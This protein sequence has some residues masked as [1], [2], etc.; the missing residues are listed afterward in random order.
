MTKRLSAA[1]R[2]ELLKR[3]RGRVHHAKGHRDKGGFDALWNKLIDLYR[4]KHFSSSLLSN[5]EDRIAV[6]ICFATINVIA[7]SIA[8]NYPKLLVWSRKPEEENQAQI[9]ETVLNYWWRHFKIQ[10]EAA[11]AVKDYLV[12]GHGWLK[13]G[14]RYVEEQRKID[15]QELAEADDLDQGTS[16]VLIPA[17][18][19]EPT[20]NDP[21]STSTSGEPEYEVT[22]DRPFV[23]RVS[24]FDI[25][26]DPEAK[27]L[28]SAKWICQKIVKPLEEVRQ[29]KRY[30]GRGRA[31]LT[32][33]SQAN[34]DWLMEGTDFPEDDIRRVT[35]YEFYDMQ[36]GTMC[37]FSHAGD[38][39]LL[40]PIPQ[41]YVFGHPFV[42]LR[43]YEV[44]DEFYPMGDVEALEP[45]QME[46]D[47]TR[48]Q[49]MNHRKRFNRKW[50]Y[51]PTAF[52]QTGMSALNKD[53]DNTLVPVMDTA[54]RPLNEVIVPIPQ[55]PVEPQLY[56]Y[57]DSTLQL[58]DRVSG[59]SEYQQGTTPDVRR[60]A[61]EASMIQDAANSRAADKMARVELFVAEVA[62][63]VVQLAQQYMTEDQVVRVIGKNG[64]PLWIPYSREDIQGE[65]DFEVEAGSTQPKNDQFRRSQA[66]QLLQAL[67]PW[68]QAGLVNAQELLRYALQY[69][70]Q[71]KN[72]DEFMASAVPQPQ[73]GQDQ[74]KSPRQSLIETMNYRDAPPDIQRQIEQA[75]GFQPSQVGGS[76]P[77]EGH[78]A[79]VVP[80][81]AGQHAQA[82]AAAGQIMAQ[83]A[84][85]QHQAQQANAG[86][87]HEAVMA[88]A[89]QQHD[90]HGRVADA[91]V[92]MDQ[93]QGQHQNAL[94][95]AAVEAY[96][97]QQAIEARHALQ[98]QNA[99]KDLGLT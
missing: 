35:L 55:V 22:E 43:N 86:R 37:V 5:S 59:A 27:T 23:E 11:L 28:E 7:P 57:E 85:L 45:L 76:S 63:K 67:T 34:P 84:N 48:S 91:A 47:K 18:P 88:H 82:G 94:Q 41:P 71:V 46:L 13:I 31:A 51:D 40:D 42:M 26:V 83:L 6:N 14:W 93:Q 53:I 4:G 54:G 69:G 96:L 79:K 36:M 98:V 81:M 10:S 52:D 89:Q 97:A 2:T 74:Q 68:A 73:Q 58:M 32:P 20:A 64:H 19:T 21:E 17:D 90:L 99:D 29:D 3:Y 30:R 62:C 70:F 75:A 66:L 49:M 65:F 25:Y 44:P 78:L 9:L 61:T 24:P 16:A 38:E 50:L 33:D 12:L 87:Q 77:A 95:Q 1:Q 15:Q 60:T 72:P 80:Q 39:M 56:Q 8:V 92:A